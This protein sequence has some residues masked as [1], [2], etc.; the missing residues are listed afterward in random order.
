MVD[1]SAKGESARQAVAQGW[2]SMQPEALQ[3]FR[4]GSLDKG[5]AA[6]VARVAGIQAAKRTSELIPLCHPLRL[7][8]VTVDI[9]PHPPDR[10]EVRAMVRCSER[11]GVEME[12]LTSASVACLTLYDM[13]KSLDKSIVIGPI[14]LL[15]KTGGKSGDYKR[16]QE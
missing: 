4:E 6:A 7:S 16:D 14:Q 13:L 15:E 12:A 1:V 5:D 2:L 9:T 10:I 3:R 8:G 11:T